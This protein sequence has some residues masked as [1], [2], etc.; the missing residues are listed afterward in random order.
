METLKKQWLE[1]KNEEK[2]NLN[3]FLSNPAVSSLSLAHNI[4][5]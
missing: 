3:S 4:N 5:K 1:N 2:I